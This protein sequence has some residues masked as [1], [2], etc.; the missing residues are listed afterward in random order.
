MPLACEQA[1]AE[2]APIALLSEFFCFALAEFFFRPRREP[3][4]RLTNDLYDTGAV[5]YQL[6][7]H[8]N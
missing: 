3:V 6:S 2:P 1:P 4:R 8:A 5:L 7:Y